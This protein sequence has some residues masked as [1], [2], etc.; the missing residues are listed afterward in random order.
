M[1]IDPGADIVVFIGCRHG[2]RCMIT[3]HEPK[4]FEDF[5]RYHPREAKEHKERC[6]KEA[7]S[8]TETG[9]S[10]FESVPLVE[11]RG[12]CGVKGEKQEWK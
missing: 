4:L 9:P 8:A 7:Q 1:P 10:T 6:D 3:D 12:F 11:R 5:I 2:N